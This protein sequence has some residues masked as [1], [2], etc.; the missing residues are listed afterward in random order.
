MTGNQ[1]NIIS[2]AKGTMITL[3][4]AV[5]RVVMRSIMIMKII[6]QKKNRRRESQ[7]STKLNTSQMKVMTRMTMTQVQWITVIIQKV[8]KK[9]PR[10]MT[11]NRKRIVPM[12]KKSLMLHSRNH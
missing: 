1:F 5:A 9:R 10:V 8:V 3:L 11:I 2:L 4:K 12:R 7:P 6:L